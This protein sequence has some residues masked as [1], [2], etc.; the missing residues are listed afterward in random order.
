MLLR[1]IGHELQVLGPSVAL[2]SW[3]DT[4]WDVVR[5]VLQDL[6]PAIDL[7]LERKYPL[8]ALVDT[9]FAHSYCSPECS[10]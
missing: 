3:E 10:E 6:L 9:H 1:I 2:E 8:H 7:G 5:H 4:H